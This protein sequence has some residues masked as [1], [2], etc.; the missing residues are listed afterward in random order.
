MAR[1]RA[2]IVEAL[3]EQIY[4]ESLADFSVPKVAKRAG[5]STR[6]VYRYFPNRDDL[7]EA[8]EAHVAETAPEPPIPETLDEVLPLVDELYSY[9]DRNS[10]LI[11]AQSI[12]RLGGEIMHR[13]RQRR[14]AASKNLLEAFFPGIA[15]RRERLK[16][17]AIVRAMMSS[18]FWR[19]LTREMGLTSDEAI[20]IVSWAIKQLTA[21]MNQR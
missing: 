1:T 5:V 8:V 19:I 3:M 10:E 2:S 6:T 18:R 4:E 13:S 21:T 11:E 16:R 17:F 12:T 20:E 9:F 7:L 14:Q 15:D